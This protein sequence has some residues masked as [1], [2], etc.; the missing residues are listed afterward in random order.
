[1]PTKTL[2]EKYGGYETV[3]KLVAIFYEKVLADDE[4]VHYFENIDMER[5]MA[6]QT[7][8]MG[9]ML[10]GSANQYTGRDLKSAHQSLKITSHHFNLVAGHLQ[11]TLLECGVENQDVE[12]IIAAVGSVRADIISE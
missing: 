5:L 2:F 1:M 12:T 7:V 11:S 9:M 3:S 8:F 10:G 6:H 4:L